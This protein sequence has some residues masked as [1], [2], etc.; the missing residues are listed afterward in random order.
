MVIDI[1]LLTMI[2]LSLGGIAI[3]V[4]RKFSSLANINLEQIP[5]ERMARIKKILIEKRLIQ[6]MEGWRNNFK[7]L[8]KETKEN[9]LIINKRVFIKFKKVLNFFKNK[10]KSIR[11][12]K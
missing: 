6:E 1:L 4:G 5:R 8:I 7:K 10:I 11:R 3:I 2:F 12:R 9:F